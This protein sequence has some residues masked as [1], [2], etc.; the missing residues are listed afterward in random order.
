MERPALALFAADYLPFK[1]PHLH[2]FTFA[3]N[4]QALRYA[5]RCTRR[6][7]P[8]NPYILALEPSEIDPALAEA[9]TRF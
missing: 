9:A 5:L 7:E 4:D 8:V 2:G 1:P 6:P 3:S